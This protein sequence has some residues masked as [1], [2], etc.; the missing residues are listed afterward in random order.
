MFGG[1]TV[2]TDRPFVVNDRVKVLGFDGYIREIGVRSTRLQTLEGRMV[3]IPN[4]TFQDTAVENVTV[5]P[6]RKVPMEIGLTYDMTPAQ[7]RRAMEILREIAGA[8]GGL[9]DDTKCAF[10]GF[11][12]SAMS[13]TF[14]YYIK[15][16]AD[17]MQT[18][19]EINL[20][21]LDRF[22]AEGLD[23]AFPTQTIYSHKVSA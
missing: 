22:T 19:T 5:E 23:M 14:I 18:Q 2:F 16:E 13:I 9:T 4:S 8:H 20:A 12:D 6:S 11:G 15:K 3:T 7:M 10:T 17:I 21:I 1:F